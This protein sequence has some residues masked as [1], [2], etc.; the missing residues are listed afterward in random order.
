MWCNFAV[1]LLVDTRD[2]AMG[3][4]LEYYGGEV[5]KNLCAP[6]Q[7]GGTLVSYYS[8]LLF[9]FTLICILKLICIPNFGV[10]LFKLSIC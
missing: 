1:N 5:W 6:P 4:I 8:S 2:I 9:F 10:C 7:Y 3:F